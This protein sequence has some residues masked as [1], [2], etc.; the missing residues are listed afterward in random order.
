[1]R[2]LSL[3]L[4]LAFTGPAMAAVPQCPTG[5]H[6]VTGRCRMIQPSIH[7]RSQAPPCGDY[8]TESTDCSN[9]P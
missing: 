7:H 8:G 5:Y 2:V 4:V 9:P 1:M 6:W 3:A